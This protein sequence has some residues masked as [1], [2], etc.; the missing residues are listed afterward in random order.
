M[1]T[2]NLKLSK[3]GSASLEIALYSFFILTIILSSLKGNREL[4]R[5]NILKIKGYLNEVKKN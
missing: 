3:N 1:E 4:S 5:K 2:W